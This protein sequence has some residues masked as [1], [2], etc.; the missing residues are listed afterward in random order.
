VAASLADLDRLASGT[1]GP[2]PPRKGPAV[3]DAPV[4]TITPRS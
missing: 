2:T 1:A 4:I 3:D